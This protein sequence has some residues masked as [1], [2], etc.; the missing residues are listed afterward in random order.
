MF[1]NIQQNINEKHTASITTTFLVL[2]AF[3]SLTISLNPIAFAQGNQTSTT[4]PS[5][6]P[7]PNQ[8]G[9][10]VTGQPETTLLNIT[11]IPAQQTNV[12]VNQTTVPV[13]PQTL[14][15]L[16]N[17][18]QSQSAANLS[19]IENKT[20][21]TPTGNATITIVNKTTVPFNQTIV[22]EGEANQTTGQQQQQPDNV[23][24]PQPSANDTGDGVGSNQ[25]QQQQQQ[26]Q[27]Q[28]GQ[29]NASQQSEAGGGGGRGVEQENQQ[30][31]TQEKG[32]DPLSQMGESLGKL[33]GQ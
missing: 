32:N 20:L 4:A 17:I 25:A 6:S 28:Q 23:T 21:V 3:V 8:T 30:N 26:G 18:T 2:L 1:S 24:S 29:A 14:Q 15:P 13:S 27:Q 22:S 10:K 7:S 9:A 33:F 31:K 19:G 16:E 11:T 12:T 5:P